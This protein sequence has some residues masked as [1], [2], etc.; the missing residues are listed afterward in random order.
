LKEGVKTKEKP[1]DAISGLHQIEKTEPTRLTQGPHNVPAPGKATFGLQ[2]VE[3]IKKI[4]ENKNK[5]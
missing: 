4:L 1:R 2:H 5:K 3:P